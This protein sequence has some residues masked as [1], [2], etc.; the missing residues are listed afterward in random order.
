MRVRPRRLASTAT[1][2]KPT[3]QFQKGQSG[4]PSGRPRGSR[5]K[6]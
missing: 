5:N 6:G 2:E 4:N 3:M 1:K